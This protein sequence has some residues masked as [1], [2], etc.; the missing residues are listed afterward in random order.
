MNGGLQSKYGNDFCDFGP[1]PYLPSIDYS[2]KA[3]FVQ[4]TLWS[5]WPESQ[6]FKCFDAQ[7]GK[8]CWTM[9]S[10]NKLQRKVKDL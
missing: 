9:F 3:I 7:T 2:P 6:Q 4:L 5:P 10:Q 1:L 8:T